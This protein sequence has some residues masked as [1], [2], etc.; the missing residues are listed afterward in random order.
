M[1]AFLE[2]SDALIT[3]NVLTSWQRPISFPEVVILLV[4]ARWA[5]I[6]YSG[7]SRYACSETV[8]KLGPMLTIK[9]ESGLSGSGF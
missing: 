7:F 2:G 3:A 6:S 8:I 1:L 5:S 4:S 9:R